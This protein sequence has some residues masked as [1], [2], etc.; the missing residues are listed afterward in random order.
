MICGDFY[1]AVNAAPPTVSFLKA[2]K[3][4][5][6]TPAPDPLDEQADRSRHQLPPAAPEWCETA[7]VIAYD[8]SDGCMIIRWDRS[9]TT[10]SAQDALTSPVDPR[11]AW[12]SKRTVRRRRCWD[13]EWRMRRTLRLGPRCPADLTLG[14]EELRRSHGHRPELDHPLHRGLLAAW[15]T[16][17]R[18]FLRRR[19]QLDRGDVRLR[20]RR[21]PLVLRSQ[22]P[23][24]PVRHPV[25]RRKHRRGPF[26]RSALIRMA[27]SR[28]EPTARCGHSDRHACVMHACLFVYRPDYG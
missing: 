1:T 7:V 17:R 25:S 8:D 24:R 26:R 2:A 10:T 4:Q 23:V 18:R 12:G 20:P 15:P 3:Y 27:Q 9:S 13:R 14:Q 6:A 11:P 19:R 22:E 21:S 28:R 16:D 5:N